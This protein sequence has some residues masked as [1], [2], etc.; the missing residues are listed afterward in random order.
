M[1]KKAL[2]KII[3][4][5]GIG[6]IIAGPII[7]Y[8]T[9]K[10]I[11]VPKKAHE[12]P[13]TSDDE[14]RDAYA[15]EFTLTKNQKAVISFSV[16]TPNITAR[17]KIFNQYYYEAEYDSN[18][19]PTGLSGED[20]IYSTFIIGQSP[21]TS[22]ATSITITEQGEVYIEFTGARNGINLISLPGRYVVVVY[23]VNSDPANDNVYFNLGLKVDGPGGILSSIF[24]IAGIIILLCYALLLSYNYLNK[25][26]RGR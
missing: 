22:G 15:K 17:L 19:D 10:V 9:D 5:I 4:I 8:A 18:S 1:E 24:V 3:L 2:I 11:L 26:R 25:L 12:I 14:L 16:F 6:L 20:F 21:S 13:E 7:G 23:G